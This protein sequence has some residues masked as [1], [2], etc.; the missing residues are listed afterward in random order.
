MLSRPISDAVPAARRTGERLSL[1][2]ALFWVGSTSLLLWS[3]AVTVLW[4]FF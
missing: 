4:R 2:A 1:R 3:A